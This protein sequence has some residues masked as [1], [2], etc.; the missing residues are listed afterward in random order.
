MPN[1]PVL[2]I[3]SAHGKVKVTTD[4]GA[5]LAAKVI[6]TA[7]AWTAE[8]LE[9]LNLPLSPLR[10]VFGWFDAPTTLFSSNRFPSFYLDEG[11]RMFYGFPD[12]NGSG[13]KLGRTDGGQPINPDQHIQNF[14]AYQSDEGELR[15]FLASYLPESNGT[16]KQGKTCLQTWS[17]DSHFIIDRHPDDKSIIIAAGFSG[18][19]FKFGSAIGEALSQIVVQERPKLDLRQF[20]L[21][22]FEN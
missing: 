22:R 11:S 7:G 10:K 4:G 13:L 17:P 3:E 12:L 6:V 5:F 9:A 14:G 8:L 19:G 1:T 21:R 16:L 20:S 2:D 15:D 18:H